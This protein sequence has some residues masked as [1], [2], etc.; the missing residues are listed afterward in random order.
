MIVVVV[1]EVVVA[2]VVVVVVLVG[3]VLQARGQEVRRSGRV[4]Q[5]SAVACLHAECAS[6]HQSG[7]TE[8]ETLNGT[9]LLI[10]VEVLCLTRIVPVIDLVAHVLGEL[11]T[12]I[13]HLSCPSMVR[14]FIKFNGKVAAASPD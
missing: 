10:H 13:T 11:A 8:M 5:N 12:A 2:V 3:H 1:M 7:G 9:S 6:V 4:A 14:L